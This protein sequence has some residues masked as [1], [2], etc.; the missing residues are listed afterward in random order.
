MLHQQYLATYGWP[1]LFPSFIV[2]IAICYDINLRIS[3]PRRIFDLWIRITSP[4]R[5][6]VRISD[7]DASIV[8]KRKPVVPS[9][10]TRA[11]SLAP[12][13]GTASTVVV[14]VFEV[15][16]TRLYL[17]NLAFCLSWVGHH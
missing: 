5:N 3:Y 11:L 6:F 17:S 13:F 16:E 8:F 7:L 10:K 9:W 15:L 4:F 12:L 1:K 2:F 14:L